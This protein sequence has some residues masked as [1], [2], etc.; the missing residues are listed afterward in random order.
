M[1]AG[2]TKLG[3][4]VDLLEVRK[5]LQRDL[6]RLHQ[7]VGVSCMRFNKDSCQVLC[8]HHDSSMN[9]PSLR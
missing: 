5:A 6:V 4:S 1:L 8:L 3:E 2:N 9:V 7:L